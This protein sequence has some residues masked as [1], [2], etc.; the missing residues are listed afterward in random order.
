MTL[1]P[2]EYFSFLNLYAWFKRGVFIGGK[3]YE[4]LSMKY[5]EIMD[6]IDAKVEKHNREELERAQ[7]KHGRTNTSRNTSQAK[8]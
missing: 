6:L 1:V 7:K 2:S 5:I 8:R 4:E 3:N